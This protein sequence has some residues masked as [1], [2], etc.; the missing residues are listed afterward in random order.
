MSFFDPIQRRKK[1]NRV[2][3]RPIGKH[4]SSL[5]SESRLCQDLGPNF[6][7]DYPFFRECITTDPWSG[8]RCTSFIHLTWIRKWILTVCVRLSPKF[9]LVVWNPIL[10]QYFFRSGST[11]PDFSKCWPQNHYISG[12]VGH[13]KLALVSLEL[14]FLLQ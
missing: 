11:L 3:F 5:D 14:K 13:T 6:N 9:C 8:F 4:F 10:N 12:M 7:A 1:R 2:A